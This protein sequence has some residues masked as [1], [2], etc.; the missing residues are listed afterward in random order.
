MSDT[1]PVHISVVLDRS[2]SMAS[3]VDD[4]VGGFNTFLDEQKSADGGGRVT[5]IQFDAQDPFEILIDGVDLIEATPLDGTRYKPRDATPLYDAIGRMIGRIDGE[6]LSR[7]DSGEPI[8]DQ[9]V[10]IVTDG[11][12]NASREFDGPTLSNLIQARQKLGW[13][14]VFLGSDESTFTEGARMSVDMANTRQWTK[15]AA[16]SKEMFARVSR[17]SSDFR[18]M[19]KEMRTR[20]SQQFFTEEPEEE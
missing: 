5:L 1:T 20:K 12:E 10:V 19:E 16:G 17:E 14:F 9:L 8:E 13:T 7:A 3:I 2:G 4:I 6:I 11:Y 15:S 18:T